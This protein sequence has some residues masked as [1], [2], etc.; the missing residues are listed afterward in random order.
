[1]TGQNDR[2]KAQEVLNLIRREFLDKVEADLSDPLDTDRL[3]IA[4]ANLED[5]ARILRRAICNMLDTDLDEAY[6]MTQLRISNN[7]KDRA[8]AAAR[9]EAEVAKRL[10]R[11]QRPKH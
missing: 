11:L 3:D 4:V 8:A 6:R 1:M 10:K 7:A 5:A 9:R 2:D